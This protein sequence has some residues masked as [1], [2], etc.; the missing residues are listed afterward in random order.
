MKKIKK[1]EKSGFIKSYWNGEESLGF[2]FWAIA[3]LGLTVLSIPMIVIETQGDVFY[4]KISNFGALLFLAYVIGVIIASVFVYV[5]LWRSASKYI[6]LKKKKKQ[7][8]IWGYLT[9]VYIVLAV[10]RSASA[11]IAG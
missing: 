7:S 9:Y 5:G 3:V 1:K 8:A 2:S 10:I 4:D 11:M 6:N